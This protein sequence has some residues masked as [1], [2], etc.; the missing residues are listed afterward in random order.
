MIIG[1]VQ[2]RQT[3]SEADR[4]F[5]QLITFPITV[6]VMSMVTS[7]IN[8]NVSFEAPASNMG[9][10]ANVADSSPDNILDHDAL[11]GT[12]NASTGDLE[13][14][15]LLINGSLVLQNPLTIDIVNDF[16]PEPVECF[17]IDIASPDVAGD[18]DIYECF[19]DDDNSDSFF[20]LH[21]ICIVDDD[22]QF[23]D[24]CLNVLLKYT[25]FPSRTICCCIC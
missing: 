16:N 15:R 24:I 23:T 19:D 18:R 7:E 5:E 25:S 11:F 10:T 14:A 9:R 8:Y 1:F 2:R 13:A 12:F 21:E 4:P 6:A 22:G 17:T 20:C 3:I